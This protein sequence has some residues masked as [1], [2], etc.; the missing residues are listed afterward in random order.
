MKPTIDGWA[1]PGQALPLMAL[2]IPL[3]TAL[4][5]AVLEIGSFLMLRLQLTD[6]LQHATRASVL[7]LDY[8]QLAGGSAV[9]RAAPCQAVT[10]D[11]APPE[12]QALV[13]TA[14][15]VLRRNLQQLRAV[16]EA[17][18]LVGTVRWTIL[19]QG[20]VCSG[21]AAQAAGLQPMICAELTVDLRSPFGLREV[22]TVLRAADTLD[23]VLWQGG[24]S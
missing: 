3:V 12:C 11:T 16:G 2:I 4:L 24:E 6:A 20:G 18:A 13:A 14:A 17:D 15:S 19:P 9:L 23:V 8:A 5:I 22:R 7:Q 21:L 10:L 1:Q